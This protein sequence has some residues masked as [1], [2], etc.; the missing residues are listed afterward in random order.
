MIV[1]A[2]GATAAGER[3]R[4]E[5]G[6]VYDSAGEILESAPNLVRVRLGPGRSA[7]HSLGWLGFG[8]RASS[9]IEVELHLSRA[10]ARQENKLTIDVRFPASPPILVTDPAWKARC[11]KSF[12]ELRAYLMG[13]TTGNG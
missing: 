13:G 4:S 9:P 1:V 2:C 12:I 6:F 5:L 8:R 11:T 3:F 10:D 7:G